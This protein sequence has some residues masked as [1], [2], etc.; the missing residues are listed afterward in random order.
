M[1]MNDEIVKPGPIDNSDI[2]ADFK[3]LKDPDMVKEYCNYQIKKGLIEDR[4]YVMLS[5][6]T[7]HYLNN[8]YQ[9]DN[10][11]RYVI[12]L[13][14]EKNITQIE[15]YLKQVNLAILFSNL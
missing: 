5:H 11:K 2:L 3:F 8:L 9:G 6:S 10:T 13:N 1:E 7:W 4:D 15:V 12:C 14:D